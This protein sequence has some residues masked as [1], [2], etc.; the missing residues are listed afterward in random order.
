MNKKSGLTLIEVLVVMAVIA[1]LST[2]AIPV[3]QKSKQQGKSLI[4]ANNL[5]QLGLA[6][7]IYAQENGHFPEGFCGNPDCHPGLSLQDSQQLGISLNDDW[8]GFWWFNF[9]ADFTGGDVA[10][11]DGILWCPSRNILESSTPENILLGNY[12]VNYSICKITMNSAA[13]FSGMPLR[14]D[15][16]KS[17]SGKL[18]VMDSGY[19]L[20][21]WKVFAPD[22][23]INSPLM[24]FELPKRQDAYYLPGAP[25]NRIRFDGGSIH[26]DQ[27][28]D[29]FDGRHSF[30]RFN[31]VFADGH[32]DKKSPESVEPSV[33]AEGVISNR[34]FWTP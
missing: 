33:D 8:R 19:A 3:M 10:K 1:L 7:S 27:R 29:A 26:E 28:S 18:L 32:V 11:Q 30:G 5:K 31:A 25:V 22:P 9:I 12:G 21:S 14:T 16:V 13:E 2:I 6:L 24:A 34:S 17:P 23:A 15:Q 4:C 20:I